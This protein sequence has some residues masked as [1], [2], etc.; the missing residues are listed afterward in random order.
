MTTITVY[1][2][3]G[4]ILRVVSC[5]HDTRYA[6]CQTGESFVDGAS[7]D[8]TQYIVGGTVTDR[9]TMQASLSAG[10]TISGVPAGATVSINGQEYEA[11]GTDI[12][13]TFDRPGDYQIKAVLW[14]YLDWETTIHAD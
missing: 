14:P 11:D 7:N 4:L 9:P 6:Q 3:A 8:S 5:Q 12:E 10:Q 13:L 2:Q 1:D